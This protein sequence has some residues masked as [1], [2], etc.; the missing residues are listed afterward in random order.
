MWP[1]G[2]TNNA[3]TAFTGV[4]MNTNENQRTGQRAWA[5]QQQSVQTPGKFLSDMREKSFLIRHINLFMQ[6]LT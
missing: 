3:Q 5:D 1:V 4:R 2:R 6:V